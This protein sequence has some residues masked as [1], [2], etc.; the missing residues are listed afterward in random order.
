[1]ELDAR[2]LQVARE[3]LEAVEHGRLHLPTTKQHESDEATT[4]TW[5]QEE[6]GSS[7]LTAATAGDSGNG[8]ERRPSI[9]AQAR[10]H[11]T[12]HIIQESTDEQHKL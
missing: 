4:C 11:E 7:V 10:A 3:L 2:Q 12:D 8:G 6:S 1:M 9:A 5:R